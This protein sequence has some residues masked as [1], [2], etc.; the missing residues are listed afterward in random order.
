MAAASKI[1]VD[2]ATVAVLCCCF[3]NITG[4]YFHIKK[5]KQMTLKAFLFI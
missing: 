2:V 5:G 1:S 3:F 4:W